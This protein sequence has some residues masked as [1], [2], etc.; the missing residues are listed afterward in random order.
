[1]Y[2]YGPFTDVQIIYRSGEKPKF[3]SKIPT[4]IFTMEVPQSHRPY[5]V[6][7]GAPPSDYTETGDIDVSQWAY[8]LF[9]ASIVILLV[10]FFIMDYYP[11]WF[12]LSTPAQPLPTWTTVEN[13]F[14]PPPPTPVDPNTVTPVAAQVAAGQ[15]Q[16]TA[17]QIKADYLAASKSAVQVQ[18][19][20]TTIQ[21]MMM[22]YQ[23][24]WSLVQ[25]K[26]SA[27]SS[28]PRSDVVQGVYNTI[29]SDMTQLSKLSSQATTALRAAN[30]AANS[31][32]PN[33]TVAAAQLT[34][35]AG[36]KSQME[37]SSS[38]FDNQ[39]QYYNALMTAYLVACNT[40]GSIKAIQTQMLKISQSVNLDYINLAAM[41][42]TA[43]GDQQQASDMCSQTGQLAT[44]P[45]HCGG[46]MTPLVQGGDC[47]ITN[48]GDSAAMTAQ[49][50]PM[51]DTSNASQMQYNQC[52]QMHTCG[53][54]AR[55]G[56]YHCINS[57]NDAQVQYMNASSQM[58][59]MNGYNSD[60]ATMYGQ[61]QNLYQQ[62]QQG[63]LA[64]PPAADAIQ[65]LLT[66]AQ[67]ILSQAKQE[68]STFE[69]LKPA[70]VAACQQ[71]GVDWTNAQGYYQDV[72]AAP[73]C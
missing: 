46:S 2:E 42:Q 19:I 61:I 63:A 51:A 4:L 67:Q 31:T 47:Q 40:V 3:F 55:V 37:S 33:P 1:M 25:R 22:I 13:Y 60:M 38:D 26:N 59:A 10:I 45:A 14:F 9:G 58:D 32:N 35:V 30:N 17:A 36:I 44:S 27:L 71:A 50:C 57:M 21:Q 65:D 68:Q 23:S 28:F 8:Y 73:P 15:T 20:V 62:S 70:I 48:S 18:V 7:G 52:V 54:P 39:I 53:L 11:S 56:S 43:Q 29:K 6:W 41:V 16:R 49:L 5:N 12:G 72:M 24:K 66:T 64:N 69:S 34:A